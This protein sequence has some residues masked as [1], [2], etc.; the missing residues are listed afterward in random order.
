MLTLDFSSVA[1]DGGEDVL[2]R[3][4]LESVRGSV[5]TFLL[6]HRDRLPSLRDLDEQIARLEDADA[7]I[8]RVVPLLLGD[9]AL[10]AGSLVF[11]GAKR[12]LFRPW[13]RDA[14]GPKKARG[15][16]RV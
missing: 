1:T 8:G 7:L 15:R 9:R 3:T 5:M 12:V 2:R 13:D 14:M 16:R 4:F 10:R 11:I 6:R